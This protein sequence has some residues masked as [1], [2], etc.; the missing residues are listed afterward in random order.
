MG[1]VNSKLQKEREKIAWDLKSRG[2]TNAQIANELQLETSTITKMMQRLTQQ[3]NGSLM[4]LIIEEKYSQIAQL[5]HVVAEAMEGWERSKMVDKTMT[6]RSVPIP[7]SGEGR[8]AKPASSLPKE[9]VV[10]IKEVDGDPRFLEVANKARAEI[11]KILGLDAA[12]K[13]INVNLESASDSQIDRI[14][15]GEDPL[16]VMYGED[17]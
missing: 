12:F 3:A 10:Q 9:N 14:I 17:E 13:V 1:K 16:I 15:A 4:A 7:A 6:T 2:W 8:N 5:R 11:R